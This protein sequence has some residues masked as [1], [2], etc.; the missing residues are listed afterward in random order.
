MLQTLKQ[1]GLRFL[2]TLLP[3]GLALLHALGLVSTGAI[4]QLDNAVYDTRL[5]ASM[6]GTLESRV[7]IVDID[8][9]SLAALGP[10]PWQREQL[11][12]LVNILFE[13]Q[14]IA[15]LGFDIVFPQ[16]DTQ[17]GGDALLADA[18]R[19]RPV[20]L[21][22]FFSNE[23][24]ARTTGVLP[25]PVLDANVLQGRPVRITRWDSAE[26]NIPALAQAAPL[27]GAFNA[28]PDKDGMVRSLPLLAEY[29][30]RA[31]ESL[32]LAVFRRV[33][34]SPAVEPGFASGFMMTRR[35]SSLESIRLQHDGQTIAIAVDERVAALVPYR[36]RGGPE[37]GS[38][39][40]VSAVEVLSGRL[41]AG[42]LRGKI[43][44][45]GTTAP[46]LKDL[47]LTPVGANYPGVET[48]AN[49]ITGLLDGHLPVRPDYALGYELVVLVASG[50]LLAFALPRMGLWAGGVLG[51]AVLMGVIGLN[52]WMH[53]REGLVLPL[54]G[55]ALMVVLTTALG[56]ASA[57]FPGRPSENCSDWPAALNP[58]TLRATYGV[59]LIATEQDRLRQPDVVWQEIDRLR[60]TPDDRPIAIYT[61]LGLA[62]ELSA[63]L[64]EE[65]RMWQQA[66]RAWRA[67]DWDACDVHLLNLQRQNAKKVL[68]RLYA[69]RVAS[70]RQMPLDPNWDGATPIE[71]IQASQPR[72]GSAGHT[73]PNSQ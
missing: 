32:A 22:Y 52:T 70:R 25:A 57:R 1:R 30:S 24:T 53:L 8:R 40:Y 44:L 64:R 16:P 37:G 4:H 11:A 45:L 50:L 31:Y 46:E 47:R 42:Q 38:F 39:G 19:D 54:A 41:P 60:L 20:V 12:R 48:H 21:G 13:Q 51:V 36:G 3:L 17:A 67:Q 63:G 18:L 9:A 2:I 68:Y 7:V 58:A 62:R 10:W 49:V 14:G 55:T 34:G 72:T 65:L 27:A 56:L 66:L 33:L 35:F 28:L 29:Q 26:S 43:V 59:D 5:R 61:P 69:E 73:M 15:V 23:P 71:T 6:P